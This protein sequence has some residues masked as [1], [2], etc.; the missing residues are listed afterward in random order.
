MPNPNQRSLSLFDVIGMIVGIVVGTGIYETAPLV[1][2][3]A[4]SSSASLLAWTLGGV[5]TLIGA[6]CYAE[7]ATKYPRRGGDYVFIQRAFGNI[8]AF[9][10]AWAQLSILISGSMGMMAFVFA[11]YM[12]YVFSLPEEASLYLA[13]SSIVALTLTNLMG[14]K[15]GKTTQ[16]TIAVLNVLGLF[17]LVAAGLWLFFTSQSVPVVSTTSSHGSYGSFGLAMIFVLYTYGGW[18]D[19]VFVTSHMQDKN[20]N[21]PRALLGGTA[22]VMALYLCVNLAYLVGLGYDEASNAKA[23]AAELLGR[24]LG[25]FGA[26]TMAFLVM[27]AALGSVNGL[28]FTGARIYVSFG[29]DFRIFRILGQWNES[30]QSPQAAIL[31]QSLMSLGWIAI[32]GSKMGR[33]FL[34]YFFVLLKLPSLEWEGYGGFATLMKCT[35]PVFWF[36]FLMT[37]ISLMVLR[38]KDKNTQSGF[39]VP[40]YPLT[41]LLFCAMCAYMLYSSIDYAGSLTIFGVLVLFIG[42]SIYFLDKKLSKY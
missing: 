18:N 30:K 6:L 13:M 21:I 29:E 5:L 17:V 1:F 34:S 12:A 31:I 32:I 15:V 26:V 39:S 37:G 19:A 28:I 42:V 4:G 7:L 8:P 40:F 10:F 20:R 38:Y 16:N 3:F 11:H 25:D 41:P 24:V 14:L 9:L 2:R 35:A 27:F 33:D 22:V 23:I 36:F